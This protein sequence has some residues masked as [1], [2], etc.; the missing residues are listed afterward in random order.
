MF[1]EV[2]LWV[3]ILATPLALALLDSQLQKRAPR[4]GVFLL[5]VALLLLLLLVAAIALPNW[6]PAW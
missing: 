2:A 3:G 6:A 1:I 5:W 4:L